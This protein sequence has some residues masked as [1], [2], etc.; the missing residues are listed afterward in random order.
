MTYMIFGTHLTAGCQSG[1]VQRSEDTCA[2]CM[3]QNIRAV[4]LVPERKGETNGEEIIYFRIR[5]RRSS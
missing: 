1:F 3:Y 5:N 2:R 4:S